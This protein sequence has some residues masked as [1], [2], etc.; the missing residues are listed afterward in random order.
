MAPLILF[1]FAVVLAGLDWFRYL[2]A[3]RANPWITSAFALAIGLYSLVRVTRTLKTLRQLRQG[4]DAERAVAQYLERFRTEGFDVFHDVPN[5][6]ANIDHVLIGPRGV[7]TIET[8]GLSKPVRGECKIQVAEGRVL[9]NGIAMSRD[10]LVQAKAQARWLSSFLKDAGFR[11][12]VQPVVVFPGWFVEPFDMKAIG[13]WAMEPKALP[14]FV[15]RASDRFT[16]DETRAMASA[17]SSYIRSK[18]E[19]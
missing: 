6:D 4:R 15:E 7:Y 14:A 5:A 2:L 19:L 10:P 9:V 3:I 8:K 16:R 13:V 12:F 11:A 18:S 1:A 17:L